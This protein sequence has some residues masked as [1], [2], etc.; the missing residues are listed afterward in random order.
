MS[1][2]ELTPKDVAELLGVSMKT[3]YRWMNEGEIEFQEI[4]PRK[5]RIRSEAV[6]RFLARRTKGVAPQEETVGEHSAE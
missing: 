6:D 5:R 3:L 1:V 4:S 2:G